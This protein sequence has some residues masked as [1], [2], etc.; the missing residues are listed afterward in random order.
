MR[1]LR[2]VLATFLAIALSKAVAQAGDFCITQTG[3]LGLTYVG[4]AFTIPF[5]GKCKSWLGFTTVIGVP[6]IS[7]GT[8]CTTSSGTSLHL[9]ITTPAPTDSAG[10]I[11]DD[12]ILPLPLGPTG[13]DAQQVLNASGVG[14]DKFVPSTVTGGSCFPSVVPIP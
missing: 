3:G 1:A 13:T 7:T 12:I 11:S 5:K 14:S 8:G 9:G 2:I 10:V 6:V 4:K